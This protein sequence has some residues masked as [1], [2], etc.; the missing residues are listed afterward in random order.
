[1][2]FM[3]KTCPECSERIPLTAAHNARFCSGACRQKAYRARSK[4]LPAALTT[5]ARWVRHDAE[6]RPLT[7]F[8]GLASVTDSRTWTTYAKASASTVGTG[9]GIV[10]GDGLGC[11]DLD[12]C[13]DGGKLA[14]WAQVIVD[15]HRAEAHL[16]EVSMSGT[17]LHIFLPMAEAPGSKIR[18]G[19][20]SIETY[21]QGRYIAV[22]GKRF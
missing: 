10:L 20:R 11:I 8:G 3:P 16:I 21:S 7:L 22:T 17:G 12:H 15:E 19:H 6:K 13:I 18:D 14:P 2:G 9:Y 1:M 4:P 5:R